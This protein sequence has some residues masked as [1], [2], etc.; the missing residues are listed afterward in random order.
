MKSI[1]KRMFLICSLHEY[2]MLSIIKNYSWLHSYILVLKLTVKYLTSILS[3][4]ECNCRDSYGKT[5]A[6]RNS[7]F[8][9]EFHINI[10]KWYC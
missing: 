1:L 8:S 3:L 7:G 6:F 4:F 9:L 10:L 2:E 5:E